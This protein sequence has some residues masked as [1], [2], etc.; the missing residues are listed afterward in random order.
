MSTINLSRG[1]WVSLRQSAWYDHNYWI[2]PFTGKFDHDRMQAA[3]VKRFSKNFLNKFGGQTHIG[4]IEEVG[5]G[6]IE[7]EHI[8][9]IG[10]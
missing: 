3:L 9:S 2:Y 7:V 6:W 10:D 5:P 1:T 8:Y 4:T